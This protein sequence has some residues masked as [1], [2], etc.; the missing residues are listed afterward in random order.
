M[1][2]AQSVSSLGVLKK[3]RKRHS[4]YELVAGNWNITSMTG[5]EHELLE[6]VKRYSLDVVDVSTT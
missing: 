3:T 1:G 4:R 6:E 2:A 5:K